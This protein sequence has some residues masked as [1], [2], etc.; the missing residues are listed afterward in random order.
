[1]ELKDFVSQTL[2]Q[3]LDGIKKSQEYA[4]EKKAA[5]NPSSPSIFGSKATSYLRGDN[6]GMIQYIDFDVAVTAVEGSETKGGI[7]IFVGSVGIGTQGKSD[8]SNTSV[9]R[10]KFSIPIAFPT[11]D[12]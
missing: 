6:G 9:S 12:N 10:I 2:T 4:K 5:I 7:G 3:I 8:S 1:M 11:Q